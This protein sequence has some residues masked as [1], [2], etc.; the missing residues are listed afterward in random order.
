LSIIFAR[1]RSTSR[2]FFD[3]SRAKKKEIHLKVGQLLLKNTKTTEIEDKIFD[4]VNH[5]NIAIEFNYK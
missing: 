4:I 1:S 2:L 3:S 5:L